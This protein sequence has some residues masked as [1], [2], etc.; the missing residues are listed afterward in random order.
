MYS[1]FQ[2]DDYKVFLQETVAA[3]DLTFAELADA[4]RVAPPYI[5]MVLRRSGH[6]SQGQALAIA[7]HLRLSED[8]CDYFLLLVSA[9]SVD[10]P[11][12]REWFMSK[13]RRIQQ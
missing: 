7:K 1:L 11:E 13:I 5:S 3:R 2:Y 4:A 10:R 12:A 9:A 6:L 8:E